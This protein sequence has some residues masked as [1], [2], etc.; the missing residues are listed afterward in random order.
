MQNSLG[1]ESVATTWLDRLGNAGP[2]AVDALR[3]FTLIRQYAL[4]LLYLYPQ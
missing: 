1:G 4:N 3:I 2:T